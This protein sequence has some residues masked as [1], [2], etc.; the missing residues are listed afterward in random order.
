LGGLGSVKS[1]LSFY[2]ESLGHIADVLSI[3]IQLLFELR[4]S[5]STESASGPFKKK[6]HVTES[7]AM[8][9]ELEDNDSNAQE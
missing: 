3:S 1:A 5:L 6:Y 2:V 4:V 7:L 9:P 8:S